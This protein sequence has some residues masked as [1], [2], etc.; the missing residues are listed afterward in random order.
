M[1]LFNFFKRKTFQSNKKT[2]WNNI[3]GTNDL[4]SILKKSAR[5]PQLIYKHSPRCSVSFITKAELHS[6][7]E[8][9]MQLSN[10]YIVNVIRQKELSNA[11]ASVLKVRHESPQVLLIFNE[12]A[13][14]K[15]SHWQIQGDEILSQ[16]SD[17]PKTNASSS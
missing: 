10:L 6:I 3:T 17:C 5:K 12:R 13:V 9:L 11:I 7:G 15:G 8:E 4:Q 14:W 2:M 1:N 16:L